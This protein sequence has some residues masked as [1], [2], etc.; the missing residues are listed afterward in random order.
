VGWRFAMVV[1]AAP[2]LLLIPLLLRLREP[3]RGASEGA[4]EP[5]TTGVAAM[6][7]A[8]KIPT[9]W[10]IIA[11]GAL[12]NFNMYALGTFMPAFLSR[13]HHVSL[14]NSGIGTGITYAIG[15][16]AGSFA[17]GWLGDHVIKKRRNGRMLWAAGITILSAPTGYLA[18]QSGSVVTA[19][20]FMTIS[21]GALCSYYG[22]V[23]SSIQD[24]VAPSMR[25][26]A[27]AIYFMAMYL[28]GASFGPLLTGKVSDMM[29]RRA[30][31]LAGSAVLTD[32]FKAIG[33]QQA[34]LIMPV[35]AVILAMVLYIG[36]RTIV[37]DIK[38][39]E[40]SVGYAQVR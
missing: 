32:A 12:L 15:G 13:I 14:A 16:L 29:A 33:L 1:A 40:A 8:L 24:I 7:A 2:A 36:S 31:E 20:A 10:W 11:S 9:L 37:G 30:A 39:R 25:A 26:T 3:K 17:G 27:M 22:L 35:L 4:H 38:R 34:M 18:I 19:V 5:G 23:Y 21:Y 28:C 6:K